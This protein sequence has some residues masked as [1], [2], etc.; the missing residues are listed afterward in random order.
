MQ[1]QKCRNCENYGEKKQ[2]KKDKNSN[3]L[4]DKKTF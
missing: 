2:K 4:M 1:G 3:T